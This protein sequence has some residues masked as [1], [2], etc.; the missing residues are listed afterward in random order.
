MQ[1]NQRDLLK[2]STYCHPYDRHISEYNS[3]NIFTNKS[4]FFWNLRYGDLLRTLLEEG[5]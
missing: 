3:K 4:K 1:R 2:G 5:L